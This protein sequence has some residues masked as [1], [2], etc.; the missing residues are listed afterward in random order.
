[1]GLSENIPQEVIA[2]DRGDFPLAAQEV[3]EGSLLEEDGSSHAQKCSA[4]GNTFLG[5]ALE[6]V[7]NSGGSAGDKDVKIYRGPNGQGW[8]EEEVITGGV[9]AGDEGVALYASGDDS[10]DSSNDLTKTQGTTNCKVGTIF[11]VTDASVNKA[12][13]KYEPAA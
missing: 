11:Y 5:K 4:N 1:M 3:Y 6:H 9:S 12:I 2:G 13:V 7:D 10:S 8:L